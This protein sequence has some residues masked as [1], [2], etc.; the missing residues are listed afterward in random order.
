MNE[1]SQIVVLES[2]VCVPVTLAGAEG[3]SVG[4]AKAIGYVEMR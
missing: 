1:K 3:T 4:T 2:W